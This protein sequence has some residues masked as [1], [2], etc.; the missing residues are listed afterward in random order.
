[1]SDIRKALEAWT[2]VL[3]KKNV[4]VD[5]GIISNFETATFFTE[6]KITAIIRPTTT[7]SIQECLKIA[8]KFHAPVYPISTGK[9]WGYGSSV[10]VKNGCVIMDLSRMNKILD[11]NEKLAYITVEPGVTFEQVNKFLQSKKSQLIMSVTGS[12]PF[13][14]LIGNILERGVGKGPYGNRYQ[15]ACGMEIV[16]PNGECIHTGFDRFKGAKA[17]QISRSGV[18]PG[19]DDMFI[20][21]NLGI[22]TKMTIWLL[23]KPNYFQVF[24]YNI[25]EESKLKELIDALRIL[26]LEG[27]LEGNFL[28]ANDYRLLSF[29]EQYS[30]KKMG[31]LP[32]T[33]YELEK[34]KKHWKW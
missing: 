5:R 34:L 24:F 9:N 29:N 11:L 1:M 33:D 20:Q 6:Q 13:S 2:K 17:G 27:T 23:P 28:L 8:N 25:K 21:S 32:L 3:S 14:S 22:V 30:S 19:F 18:G 16:L 26:K 31:K 12:S 4:I 10:P 15:Y 7:K